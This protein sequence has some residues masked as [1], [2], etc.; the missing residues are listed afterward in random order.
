MNGYMKAYHCILDYALENLSGSCFV[1]F[2][3]IYRKT[4]GWNKFQDNI[5][6]TSF[7]KETGLKRNCVIDSISKLEK[8]RWIHVSREVTGGDRSPKKK[9]RPYN[10]YSV[11]ELV[12]NPNQ[13]E[14]PTSCKDKPTTGL[15]NQPKESTTGLKNQLSK[16]K[17]LKD[18]KKKTT[19]TIPDTGNI[20]EGE[21]EEKEEAVVVPVTPITEDVTKLQ[22]AM[23]D[24]WKW[25]TQPPAQVD[26]MTTIQEY[27]GVQKLLE[28][29]QRS[30]IVPYKKTP[31]G[32]LSC[33]C[34]YAA[35][36]TWGMTRIE[37]SP[38]EPKINDLK[39][40]IEVLKES[41]A[42]AKDTPTEEYIPERGRDIPTDKAGYKKWVVDNLQ[43]QLINRKFA[44][45]KLEGVG[46]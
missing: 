16:D 15:K 41:I 34:S 1:I 43:N 38:T 25:M 32:A 5:P 44:L 9:G 14:K 21:A 26:C 30:P 45:K 11:G 42:T 46:R 28:A 23:Q 3:Y 33:V 4:I 39:R 27:G 40:E 31:E 7:I 2:Y 35:H 20:P 8:D 18:T 17:D 10:L 6:L 29:V 12:W 19:T 24:K 37:S 22:K 36:P 13:L